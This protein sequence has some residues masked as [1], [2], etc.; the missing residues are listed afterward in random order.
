MS[1]QAIEH[2][3]TYE[4]AD[5]VIELVDNGVVLCRVGYSVISLLNREVFVWLIPT[6]DFSA[7][8]TK[9]MLGMW[10]RATAGW[11]TVAAGIRKDEPKAQRFAKF[12]GF[13]HV[14]PYTEEH[15]LWLLQRH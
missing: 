2:H 8:H 12:F 14:G 6:A 7:K 10:Q 11:H 4:N 15:D 3:G 1:V 5:S 13:K 9:V